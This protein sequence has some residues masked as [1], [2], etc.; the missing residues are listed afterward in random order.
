MFEFEAMLSG[1]SNM[2]IKRAVHVYVNHNN[3]IVIAFSH[4]MHFN[5]KTGKLVA[6]D[7][8]RPRQNGRRFADDTFKRIFLNENISIEIELSLKFCS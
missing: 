1:V 3:G 8:F 5:K 4:S 2:I 6:V 7:I